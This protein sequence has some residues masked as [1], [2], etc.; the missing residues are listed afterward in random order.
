VS[1]LLPA[2]GS[3]TLS[4]IESQPAVWTQAL[5]L[6]DEAIAALPGTGESVIAIGCGT[7][8]YVLDAFARRRQQLSGSLTR[9]A[10]ASEFDDLGDYDRVLYLS[11]SGTTSDL[12]RVQAQ[13]NDRIPSVALC[14]TP[15]SPLT[16]AVDDAV[17]LPF[18]DEHSVVQTR[19]ATSA[20]TVLR[21]S[22]GEDVSAVPSH[23]VAALAD[24]LPVEPADA[25]HFVF[26]G[27]G[28]TVG[29]AHEAALK[30]REAALVHA[31]AY[32]IGEYRHGPIAVAGPRTLI[33]SF[34]DVPPDI[35][36]A[37]AET[38]A[39]LVEP[40]RD[41]VAD[42][43]LVHRLAVAVAQSK[44]IDSDRPRYLSRSVVAD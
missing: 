1:E 36:R 38:G 14:G 32:P 9:A 3:E 37:I 21:R 33:W 29:L 10:I 30:C 43:V 8:Y 27:T 11:R 34:C 7:S 40:R 41:P 4:E 15:G 5:A 39:R 22:I 24:A 31:E 26:L 35:G 17:L 18:A 16:E 6:P 25:D 23:G 12:L 19:F 28:W 2:L 44:N 13:L 20:L 42:L